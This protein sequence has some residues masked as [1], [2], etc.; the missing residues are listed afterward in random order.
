MNEEQWS[1]NVE[2]ND[3]W[4]NDLYDTREEAE[5]NGRNW[6]IEKGLARFAVGKFECVP[7]PT[8]MYIDNIFENLDDEYCNACCNPDAD[9]EPFYESNIPENKEAQERLS[10]KIREAIQAYVNEVGIISNWYRTVES[11][12]IEIDPY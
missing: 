7:I 3:L 9:L 12:I 10:E 4:E 8:E 11:Q 2:G 6:A 5:N 1:F